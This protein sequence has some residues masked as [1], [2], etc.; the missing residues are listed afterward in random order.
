MALFAF[1]LCFVLSKTSILL[2][3]AFLLCY[4]LYRFI[5]TFKSHPWRNAF[6]SALLVGGSVVL[7]LASF[8]AAFD[9]FAPDFSSFMKNFLRSIS[10]YGSFDS[11]LDIWEPLLRGA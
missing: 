9:S 2:S 3:A 5:A 8:T 1:T 4:L 11:R 6:W 7:G 10:Q